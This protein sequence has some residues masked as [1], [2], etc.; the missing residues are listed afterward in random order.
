MYDKGVHTEDE[1]NKNEKVHY[2]NE[3][4]CETCYYLVKLVRYA[5]LVWIRDT[6]TA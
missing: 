5:A 4:L 3:S 6:D 1:H 2:I